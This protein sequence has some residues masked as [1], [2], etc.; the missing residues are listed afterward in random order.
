MQGLKDKMTKLKKRSIEQRAVN[1]LQS[2]TEG[3]TKE[4]SEQSVP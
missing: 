2:R 3:G 1:A 4:Q